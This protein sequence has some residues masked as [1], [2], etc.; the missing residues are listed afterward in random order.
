MLT[1]IAFLLVL[2]VL[3]LTHE[4]G[5]FIAARKAGIKVE[6]FGVG[7]PPRLWH[8]KIGETIYS[9]NALPLGGFVRLYGESLQEAEK[10]KQDKNRSF[11]AKSKKSRLAVIIAGVV[12]NFLLAVVIFSVTYTSTG[13]PKPSDEV[14]IIGVLPDTPAAQAGILAEDRIVGFEGQAVENTE[15]FIRISEGREGETVELVVE[16]D[17]Q[18]L[19]FSLLV[20]EDPP[21]GEGPMGVVISGVKMVHYPFW[22]M[23][24]RGAVEGFKEAFA[25]TKLILQSVGSMFGRLLTSGEVPR[26]IAG[27][28]GIFQ[29]TGGVAREGRMALWQFLGILSVNLA[30]LNIMPLPALDGGRL[31]FL[32]Y[33][34]LVR[35]RPS[36]KIEN[37]ANTAGMA[38]IVVF[39]VLVTL[40]DLNRIITTTDLSS[41]LQSIWPF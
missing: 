16:R 12:A 10:I 15:H 28:L 3:V 14:T 13:I 4:L 29:I 17:R 39:I 34:A 32:I 41:R 2:S 19:A 37:W 24:L 1:L 21:A 25:W 9:V 26:E 6:E 8:K 5:H 22:Q 33:E 38:F 30:V 18:E 27:P 20:R 36:P 23:P 7:Y 40:N 31:V 35:R 11:W